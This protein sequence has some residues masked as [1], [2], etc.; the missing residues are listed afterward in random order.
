M[1][2][3]TT[4]LVP[5]PV[6]T[7]LA[8]V[9]LAN[10]TSSLVDFAPAADTIP[11]TFA[12]ADNASGI[13]TTGF[14]V[15]WPSASDD[16]SPSSDIDYLIWYAVG[17]TPSLAVDP[18][19]ITPKA[20]TSKVFT[21]LVPGTEYHV[22]VRARDQAGNVDTNTTDLVVNTTADTADPTFAGLDAA[23]Y[24]ETG[25]T[26]RVVLSWDPATDVLSGVSFYRIYRAT[27]S[28][29]Q[30][31]ASPTASVTGAVG[32]YE[33]TSV[34][35]GTTYYYVV[36]AEDGEGNEDAN[37]A[38]EGVYV[39]DVAPST[40]SPSQSA[41]TTTSITVSW[42]AATDDITSTGDLIYE[43]YLRLPP[44]AFD[45]DH[46]A[47][48][49]GPG[50]LS[51]TLSGLAPDTTYEV[52]VLARD[53][54]S[55]KSTPNPESVFTDPDTTPP[56]FAGVERAERSAPLGIV[57]AWSSATD[58]I[59][60]AQ[61]IRYRIYRATTSGAQ[62]FASPLATTDPGVGYYEDDTVAEGAAYYYVVRAVDE[63]D[64]EDT[65]TVE[66]TKTADSV[67]SLPPVIS[68]LSPPAGSVLEPN[69]PVSFDV[70]DD[71]GFRRIIVTVTQ[72]GEGVEEVAHDGEDFRG[73]YQNVS[74]RTLID[75]GWH[76][77]VR[78]LGGWSSAPTVR[79][80]AIDVG[81]NEGTL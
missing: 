2:D 17:A 80:F 46:P 19:F 11:P 31:F 57:L 32:F 56:T 47:V 65:N 30:N 39:G 13:T 81:G 10:R 44:A 23:T 20:A 77:A 55:N 72:A 63:A 49:T 25:G 35:A 58:D 15:N 3:R 75:E 41:N 34:V 16:T 68:N 28:G 27:T 50:E 33:D 29:G 62:N 59:S 48:V 54:A 12:G 36:R 42:S 26:P 74:S 14:T 40:V 53:E 8:S 69:D 5:V 70:T 60:L 1:A 78:R 21:G 73:Y 66:V 51:A 38:E 64:N 43:V 71:K 37:T 4:E 76:Y 18:A 45:Y 22:V 61:D 9:A 67:D 6:W 79:V 52:D 24:T 7:P